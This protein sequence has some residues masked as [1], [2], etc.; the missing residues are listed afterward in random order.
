MS[1]SKKLGYLVPQFPGQ[2]HI[3]FW[4]EIEHLEKLGVDV[5]IFSTKPPPQ[6]LICHEWSHDAID[7]TT[8]LASRSI[9]KLITALRRLPLRE[10][11]SEISRDGKN[12]LRDFLISVPAAQRLIAECKRHGITHVHAHSCG[13]AALIAATANRIS[14]LNY[15]LTLHGPLQDYGLGQCFKWRKA[16]FATIIT[17]GLLAEMRRQMAADMPE[18]IHVQ[19][20][21]VDTAVMRRDTPYKAPAASEPLYVFCCARLN[22]VKGHQD[23]INAV[24]IM[25]DQGVD[26]HLEI[27]GEDDDGGSGFRKV[28]EREINKLNLGDHVILLGAIDAED[29]RRRLCKSHLFVLASWAEPLGVAYMEAMS[30][31]TPTIGT[32]AGGV[33]ELIENDVD[34]ILVPPR[35]P[36]AIAGAMLRLAR[37]PASLQRLSAAGRKTVEERFSSEQGAK[38]LMKEIWKS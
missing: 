35:D 33:R 32:A 36:E 27:A 6:G 14:G 25:R 21:G 38:L 7:R 29:V 37:D 11:A 13:R 22:V 34:G 17:Q 20:M 28:L 12:V 19:A 23:L 8:Y 15:S 31:G 4:R 18:I 16:S 3:F 1:Q 9:A 24:A 26:V 2:T 30:C 5:H 10:I